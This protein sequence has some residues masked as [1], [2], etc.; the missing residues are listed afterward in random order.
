MDDNFYLLELSSPMFQDPNQDSHHPQ[1]AAFRGAVIHPDLY[2]AV[3]VLPT[4]TSIHCRHGTTD[5]WSFHEDFWMGNG[6][7]QWVF[8][9]KNPLSWCSIPQTEKWLLIEWERHL[10]GGK[11]IG[12]ARANSS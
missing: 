2:G 12:L 3:S 1:F 6:T 8:F 11:L 9:H 5:D 4:W 7:D 10:I